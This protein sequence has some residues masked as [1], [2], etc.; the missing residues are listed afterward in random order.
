MPCRT[1]ASIAWSRFPG[2][3][4]GALTPPCAP[5]YSIDKF[6]DIRFSGIGGAFWDGKVER[7]GAAK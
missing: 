6:T 3:Q 4:T 7:E 1:L 2:T 5:S